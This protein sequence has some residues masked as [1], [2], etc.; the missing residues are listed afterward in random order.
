MKQIAFILVA[1]FSQ[2]SQ[3]TLINPC[4]TPLAFGGKTVNVLEMGK[5]RKK[6]RKVGV[7]FISHKQSYPKAGCLR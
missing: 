3:H 1:T 7:R 2:R 5:L 4:S 6:E